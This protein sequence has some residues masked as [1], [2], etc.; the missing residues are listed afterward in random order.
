M[1]NLKEEVGKQ[2]VMQLK[3]VRNTEQ[4]NYNDTTS[5]FRAV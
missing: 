4:C 1:L 2:V 5:H 3:P